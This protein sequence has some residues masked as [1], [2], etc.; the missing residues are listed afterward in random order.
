MC[1][2]TASATRRVR[3][4]LAGRNLDDSLLSALPAPGPGVGEELDIYA[5]IEAEDRHLDDRYLDD[6]CADNDRSSQDDH[7]GVLRAAAGGAV[8]AVRSVTVLQGAREEPEPP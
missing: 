1:R 2:H 6:E 8:Q 5:V 3:A 4:A 7:D